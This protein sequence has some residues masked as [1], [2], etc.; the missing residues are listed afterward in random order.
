VRPGSGLH[1]ILRVTGRVILS[2]IVLALVTAQR[3]GEL[4]LASRNTRRLKTQGAIE[5][6]ARHYPLLVV[7]HG[8]WL[9]GLWWLAWDRYVSLAWLGVFI[10]LQG[11][12]VWVIA[13]LGGRWTTRIIV[14]PGAPLIRRG[15]YRFIS[16]PNYTVVAAEIAVLPLAFDLPVYAV[17]FTVLNAIVLFIRIREENRALALFNAAAT[18]GPAPNP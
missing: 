18:S 10:V 9:I 7:L 8:A 3:L 11:L 2:I 1:G 5:I 12:R 6:G 13:S 16:H 15:P 14:L 4:V 17:L